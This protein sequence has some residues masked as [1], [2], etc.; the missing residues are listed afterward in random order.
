MREQVELLEHHADFLADLGQ[1][2][3]V[4]ALRGE[5]LAVDHQFA[6]F[7]FFQAVHAAD[8][9]GFA[10]A[11]G[12]DDHHH[13]TLLDRQVYVLEDMQLAEVLVHALHFYD[14]SHGYLSFRQMPVRAA[15]PGGGSMT[16]TG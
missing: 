7:E 2:L 13:F 3:L 1:G 10:G 15:L 11:A 6:G 16:G 4:A 14:M 8:Q 12:A 9:G 5:R